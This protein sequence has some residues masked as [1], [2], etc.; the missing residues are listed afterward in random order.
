[1]ATVEAAALLTTT[2]PTT[3]HMAIK[4][5]QILINAKDNASA[6]FTSLQAKVAAVGAA[7]ASYFGGA[8][9]RRRGQGR[10]RP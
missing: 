10:S 5:I 2:Q 4:P 3:D 1:L 8:G 9:L 7:I 6:V